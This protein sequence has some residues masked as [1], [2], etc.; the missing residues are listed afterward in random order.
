MYRF[1][2]PTGTTAGDLRDLVTSA[3]SGIKLNNYV[4]IGATIDDGKVAFVITTDSAARDSGVSAA[5]VLKVMLPAVDGRGGGSAEM[6]Q[7][8]GSNVA[9]LDASLSAAAAGIES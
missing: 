7:G 8:G 9:G 2:A 5:G 3:K 1:T 4:L 6:S